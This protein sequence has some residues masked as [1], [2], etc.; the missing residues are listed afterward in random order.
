MNT[1]SDAHVMVMLE[2]LAAV[3]GMPQ[4]LTEE[5][6]PKFFAEYVA[7][8]S[9]FDATTLRKAGDRALR[10]CKWWPK[11][12]ELIDFCEAALP[13]P[14][15]DSEAHRL[16]KHRDEMV[17]QAAREYMMHSKSS[18]ID[19]AM[20][21]GW[22]RSL[23][24]VARDVIRC[25]YERDGSLPTPAMMMAFRMPSQDVEY[26]AG[27]GQSHLNYDVAMI[28]A[29]R[30]KGPAVEPLKPISRE[31]APAVTAALVEAMKGGGKIA[32]DATKAQWERGRA[33]E[34]EAMQQASGNAI[35]KQ[36][37]TRTSR[38]MSGERE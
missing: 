16:I 21:Q 26:Y 13:T 32:G 20:S 15:G 33:A 4:N 1:R 29:A 8:L 23:E 3:F 19:M 2:R 34:F 37:L 36:S 7:A 24:D 5:A 12:A 27:H 35:H 22:G 18:L 9:G 11:P 25:C 31:E 28:L 10:H 17:K 38:R 30:G 6:T 14:T